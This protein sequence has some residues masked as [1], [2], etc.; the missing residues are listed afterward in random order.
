M[1]KSVKPL[2]RKAMPDGVRRSSIQWPSGISLP[3]GLNDGHGRCRLL[4]TKD[5]VTANMQTDKAAFEGWALVLKA[6]LGNEVAETIELEWTAPEPAEL[7]SS[8]FCHYLLIG[9]Q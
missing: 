6:W 2:L 3:F 7:G 5:A 4:L 8:A 9:M 1:P